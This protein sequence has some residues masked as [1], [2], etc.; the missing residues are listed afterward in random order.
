MRSGS[1]TPHPSAQPSS[2]EGPVPGQKE[3]TLHARAALT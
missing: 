1:A 3:S 2:Q